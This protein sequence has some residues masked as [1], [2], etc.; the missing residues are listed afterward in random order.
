LACLSDSCSDSQ[1]SANVGGGGS[2][3]YDDEDDNNKD[4]ALWEEND[5]DFCMKPFCASSR[6]KP[7]Q[8]RQMVLS[9]Q[10]L[11]TQFF[12]AKFV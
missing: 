4:W 12:S 3:S 2:C 9:P 6:Y 1:A 10:E 11:F 5:H 8:N 7:H